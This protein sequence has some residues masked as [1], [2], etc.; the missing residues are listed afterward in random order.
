MLYVSAVIRAEPKK[1]F[2]N[3]FA[4]PGVPAGIWL[5]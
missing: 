3:V 2:V 5:I 4:Y 1:G